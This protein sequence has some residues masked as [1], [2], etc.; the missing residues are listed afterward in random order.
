MKKAYGWKDGEKFYLSLFPKPKD[1]E[2]VR[3]STPYD[4]Q[5][6][7]VAEVERRGMIVEWLQQ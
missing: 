5:S 1:G 6:E 3:P 7:A 2:K 4:T